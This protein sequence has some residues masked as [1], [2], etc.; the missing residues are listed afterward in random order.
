MTFVL[1]L[2]ADAAEPGTWAQIMRFWS[3]QDRAVQTAAAGIV[4]LAIS[5]GTLGCFV[6]LR[7]MSLL[8]DS[9]GH[10][11]LPGVCLGFLVTLTKNP[12]WIL[13]GA[14]LSAVVASWLIGFIQRHSRLKAD[15][16]M[17]LVLSGFF[18]VGTVLLTRLQRIPAGEQ[19][20]LNQFLFGQA[21]AVNEQDLWFMGTLSVA[22]VT[23]VA[24]TFKEMVAASFDEGFAAVLGLPVRGLHYLLMGL[25]GL[26]IVI[27]MQAVGM[28][29][30]SAMLIIPPATSLLLT[31]RMRNMVLLS[32]AIAIAAGL[33]G[34]NLSFL[35]SFPTGPFV[36]LAL[37]VLFVAAYLGSPRHGVVVRAVR[38]WQQA[39][40]TERE[41]GLKSIYLALA[42]E[43]RANGVSLARLA[44]FRKE[45]PNTTRHLA[46]ALVRRGWAL[47]DDD[48]V[49]LTERGNARARELERN[50]RLWELFL[51]HEVNLPLDHTQRDAENI[52]HI[53]G[54]DLVR[55]LEA[56]YEERH[57]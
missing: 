33:A 30:V 41:N 47:L 55:E 32:V 27:S 21:S 46:R 12:W 3:F 1:P 8:G 50:Y 28:V 34:L 16:A 51:T 49:S 54:P 2:L 38:H 45:S 36:V 11:V 35:G 42:G 44:E 56:K 17:G 39:R 18:G 29:L 5:S 14:L 24:A 31:D 20:G 53:L 4:L 9:L 25:T 10:A 57:A 22:I 15:V 37:S 23:C 7:R 40:R 43:P 48:I 13:T 26:S 52:E 6:V 19:A